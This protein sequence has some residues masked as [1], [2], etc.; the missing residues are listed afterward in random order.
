MST[1]WLT[2]IENGKIR[3]KIKVPFDE[4]DLITS[5]INFTSIAESKVS[6]QHENFPIKF[7][8]CNN[9][10]HASKEKKNIKCE[11]KLSL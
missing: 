4:V 8:Y 10:Y 5:L 7:V 3:V 9:I 2:K 6:I 11:K 1:I